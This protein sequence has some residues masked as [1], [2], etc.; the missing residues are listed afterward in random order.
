MLIEEPLGPED[1]KR[2]VVIDISD[3]E[4][5]GEG[6]GHPHNRMRP[7]TSRHHPPMLPPHP[8]QAMPGQVILLNRSVMP[9]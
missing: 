5:Y 9:I 8:P 1:T 3:D 4:E 2:N 6:A 7:S